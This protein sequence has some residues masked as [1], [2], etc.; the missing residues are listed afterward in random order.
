MERIEATRQQYFDRR[1]L[2]FLFQL[3][4][5]AAWKLLHQVGPTTGLGGCSAPA[6]DCRLE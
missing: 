5:T 2:E 6:P 4:T 1:D 3:Q